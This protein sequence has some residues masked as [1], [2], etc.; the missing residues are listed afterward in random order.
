MRV[1]TKVGKTSIPQALGLALVHP[2]SSKRR[3]IT[4]VQPVDRDEGPEV[5][6]EMSTGNYQLVYK[7]RWIRRPQTT[8]A[9]TSPQGE[10][11]TGRDAHN[12][13]EQ[14]LRETLD[15][16]MRRA[17]QVDQ[18]T[19]LAL[20]NFSLRPLLSALELAAGGD[21]ASDDEEP[22]LERVREEYGEY[23][24]PTGRPKGDRRTS[25]ERVERAEGEV[26]DLK[27]E[28]EDIE[29]DVAEMGRLRD[30]AVRISATRDDSETS[31]Q[32]LS[33]RWA[34]IERMKVEVES[35][36]AM[37]R[38]A[39]SKRDQVAGEWGRRQEMIGDFD[40][41][42]EELAA[43][44]A[45]VERAAPAL[46][47]AMRR[48][49]ETSEAH[50]KSAAALR[51][52]EEKRDLAIKDR[53]FLRQQ[54]EVAQITERFVRYRKAERTLREAE[55]YLEFSKV[56][57]A[58]VGEIENAYLEDQRARAATESAAASIE[59][60]ALAEVTLRVGGKEVRL[61]AK[62]VVKEQ[63]EDE[64]ELVV[65]DV[66]RLRVSAGPD[67]KER[68]E[69]SSRAME[70]YRRTCDGYG[71][72]DLNEA[73]RAA[74]QRR[75]ALRN[76][77]EARVSI[78]ENLRD[79]TPD[80][81]LANI[82]QLTER[83]AAYPSERP[84]HPPLPADYPEADGI[85]MKAE[86]L[87]GDCRSEL[88]SREDAAEKAKGELDKTRGNQDE[89]EVRRRVAV[90]NRDEAGARLE[91]ARA[92]QSDEGM[93]GDLAVAQREFDDSLKSLEDVRAQMRAADPDSLKARLDNARAAKRRAMQNLETNR[94]RQRS[95][96]ASLDYRSERGPQGSYDQAL[97]QLQ[98]VLREHERIES[99]ATAAKLLY[100][101]FERHRS[102]ARQR[103]VQPFKER[104]DQFGR[105][106][107]GP[108]FEVELG[109]ELQIVSRKLDGVKLEVGQLSTGAQEQ[110]GVISRLACAAIVS[111]EDGG[112]PVMIDDALGWSDP[113]RL[114]KMGAAIAAAGRQCQ[115]VVLT[116][117]PGR[118]SHV[119]NAKVVPLRGAGG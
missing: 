68:A 29:R 16:D 55:E 38:A 90:G 74:Q 103:Y 43:L 107:F 94:E 66:L 98:G 114:E 33:E 92:V 13:M 59:A 6:I 62:E 35:R 24:T 19:E 30:E 57:E 104:I 97:S 113:Q 1:R 110:L 14:I 7:K 91:K 76:R 71:V 11:H 118:Y 20:P 63:V 10:N 64:V 8:L 58:A 108:T 3:E 119:G 48:S 87:V 46:A 4:S 15:D 116:C 56:D 89:L 36:E 12:R 27:K 9:V 25:R 73:R 115:V 96:Q 117:T 21:A 41:R 5:E 111:P 17:L 77:K 100:E 40:K 105:I 49:D 99:R 31:E 88:R 106:V 69:Q 37:H 82:E 50:R 18:G 93:A 101:T 85:A 39:E 65:P 60:E 84:E 52:A 67:A 54:I 44:E 45:D 109:D 102:R 26:A 95:L 75:D 86:G 70:A 28:V 81:M 72:A 23:W 79:W 47:A 61:S 22:L 42:R 53:D 2:D 83:V 32:E 80:I 112:A 51:D 78:K 34:S